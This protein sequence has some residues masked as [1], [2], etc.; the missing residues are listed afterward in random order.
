M[1]V[2]LGTI[3]VFFSLLWYF[4]IDLMRKAAQKNEKQ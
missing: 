4:L 3:V 2:L 1:I